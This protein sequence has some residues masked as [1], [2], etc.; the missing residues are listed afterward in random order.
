M[1]KNHFQALKEK[2]VLTSVILSKIFNEQK[3]FA[4]HYRIT[5]AQ[6]TTHFKPE[7]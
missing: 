7:A 4:F 5:F 1:K 2:A 3:T 6:I